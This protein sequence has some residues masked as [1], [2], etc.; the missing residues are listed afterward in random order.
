LLKTGGR[1]SRVITYLAQEFKGFY[2]IIGSL[3]EVVENR[4][5]L[6]EIF[7]LAANHRG[8]ETDFLLSIESAVERA[9]Q[10]H[11]GKAENDGV[12]L[13]TYFKA[14]GRQWHTVALTT[15]NN[16]LIPHSKA[17]LEDERRLFYVA[18]T[19]ATANVLVSYVGKSCN[20]KV[21][22]SRFLTEAGLLDTSRV[23]MPV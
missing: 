19:R 21:T 16:G 3:E 8:R 6:G 11:A 14:K 17:N 13:L 12:A 4:V 20:N 18:L 15:C 22:P 9:R 7:D 5:P 23:G 10:T 2:G 1:L